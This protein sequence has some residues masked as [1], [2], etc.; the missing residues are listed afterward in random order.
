MPISTG[1]NTNEGTYYVPAKMS[2]SDEFTPFFRTLL[3]AFTEKEIRTIDKLYPDPA[4]NSSSAYVE[5]RDIPVGPQ[6]KR[7][8]AAYGYYAY[9]CPAR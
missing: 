9:A 8:Q 1:F 4:L 7:I 3:P 5:T 2:I 6:Y